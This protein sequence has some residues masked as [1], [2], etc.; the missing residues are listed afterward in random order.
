MWGNSCYNASLSFQIPCRRSTKQVA[1][2]QQFAYPFQPLQGSLAGGQQRKSLK[3]VGKQPLWSFPSWQ[4]FSPVLSASSL[5]N[6]FQFVHEKRWWCT[7]SPGTFSF[8][9][10][11]FCTGP[12]KKSAGRAD[13]AT[14]HVKSG[15]TWAN[16]GSWQALRTGWE[17][18][19][20]YVKPY[21]SYFSTTTWHVEF[22]IKLLSPE[23]LHSFYLYAKQ[24]P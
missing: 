12:T 5:A 20:A 3:G 11:T 8:F 4:R 17:G 9:F 2:S 6:P 7:P 15:G 21:P 22:L 16:P 14:L 19:G 10:Q 24:E 18:N 13:A 23:N 1:S